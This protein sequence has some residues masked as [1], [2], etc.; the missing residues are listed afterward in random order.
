M[1][2]RGVKNHDFCDVIYERPLSCVSWC[3]IIV[4][5]VVQMY[6]YLC[7]SDWAFLHATGRLESLRTLE[8]LPNTVISLV[9]PKI[10]KTGLWFTSAL[11]NLSQYKDPFFNKDNSLGPPPKRTCGGVTPRGVPRGG[12][13]V[14]KQNIF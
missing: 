1:R 5:Y 4:R 14:H 8:P 13:P 10:T 3:S 6:M 9:N 2:D 7:N 12:A 11:L